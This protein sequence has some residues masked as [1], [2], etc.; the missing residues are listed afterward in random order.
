MV[1]TTALSALLNLFM[2][3]FAFHGFGTILDDN[4]KCYRFQTAI[5]QEAQA[6][7]TYVRDKNADSL[8]AYHTACEET[9]ARAQLPALLLRSHRRRALCEDLV[10]PKCV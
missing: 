6:F 10:H 3:N 2:A 1:L 5:S 8:K 9:E 4:A 7:N